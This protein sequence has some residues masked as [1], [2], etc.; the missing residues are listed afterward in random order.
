[1][2]NPEPNPID[3]IQGIKSSTDALHQG[4]D[5]LYLY[6]VVTLE[7][8]HDSQK[9]THLKL[10]PA[11]EEYIHLSTEQ[12]IFDVI[13]NFYSSEEEVVVLTLDIYA[14]EG[15]LV[16]EMI[17]KKGSTGYYHLIDGAIPMEAVVEFNHYAIEK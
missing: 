10:L 3:R 11:D 13:E 16:E 17:P 2:S 14:L 15:R 9:A 5:T 4:F 6:K 12:K 1:M 7:Q 8:W